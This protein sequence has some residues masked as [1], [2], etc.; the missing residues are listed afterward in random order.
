MGLREWVGFLWFSW[1]K[2]RWK[3]GI[4]ISQADMGQ[5]KAGVLIERLPEELNCAIQSGQRTLVPIEATLEIKLIRLAIIG[6]M[7][8]KS[9]LLLPREANSQLAANLLRDLV[10]NRLDVFL[11]AVIAPKPQAFVIPRID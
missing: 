4:A 6:R 3:Q 9:L 11:L 5:G 8:H 1:R 7:L 2:A 10:L